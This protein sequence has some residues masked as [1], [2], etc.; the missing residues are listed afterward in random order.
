MVL[1]IRSVPIDQLESDERRGDWVEFV[2]VAK[3]LKV[4]SWKRDCS[5]QKHP[6]YRYDA[7]SM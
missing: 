2:G 5:V 3:A 4:D 7:D 6:T 1:W